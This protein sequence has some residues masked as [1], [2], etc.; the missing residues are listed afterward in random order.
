MKLNF[1]NNYQI[2][3]K[4]INILFNLFPPFSFIKIHFNQKIEKK[5]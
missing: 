2:L 4:N 3:Y 5:N 1:I